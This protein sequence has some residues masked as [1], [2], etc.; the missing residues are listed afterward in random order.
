MRTHLQ[1]LDLLE[2]RFIADAQLVFD[3]ADPFTLM[4][5][6]NEDLFSGGLTGTGFRSVR[7][8]TR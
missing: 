1:Q 3:D 5:F 4:A 6:L 2:E 8:S 7:K